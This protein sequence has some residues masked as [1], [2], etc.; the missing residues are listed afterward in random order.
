M[1]QTN[2]KDQAWILK[3]LFRLDLQCHHHHRHPPC[4]RT[5]TPWA[6]RPRAS[7]RRAAKPITIIINIIIVVIIMMT[8][9]SSSSSSQEHHPYDRPLTLGAAA[10]G[11]G[12]TLGA[13]G[14]A[15]CWVST[16]IGQL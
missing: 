14:A 3:I 6:P 16:G 10:T 5:R 7:P 1:P 9:S 13:A 8:S 12:A 2:A 11:L 4:Q 15:A